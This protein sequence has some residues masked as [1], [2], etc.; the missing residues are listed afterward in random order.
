MNRSYI[1]A[2]AIFVAVVLLF[3]VGTLLNGG[4]ASPDAEQAETSHRF[5]VVVR[6]VEARM[7]PASLSLRGHTEAFREVVARAETGGR[8]AEAQRLEGTRVAAGDVLCRL[9]VDSRSA[10]VQQAEADLRA[11]QL[12]YDA[13]AELSERGHR[14]ANQVAA[15]EAA[16]DAA[17]ARL[18]AAREELAN[19]NIAAPFDGIFDG[20]AAEVGDF[21][22]A[23]DACGTVVQ[24]DPILVVAEV[25]ERHV[26]ELE[27][28]M[29]GSARLVTGQTVDGTIRFVERRADPATRTF[30]VELEAPNPDHAIRA[31]IT[32]E[33]RLDLPEEPAHR[34][35][36]S[37]LALN[38]EGVLGVRI[39]EEG[40]RVRFVPVE[41]LS[42]DG[43]Q[44]WVA[45]LP[46]RAEVIV[47]GQD[48]VADGVE[49][50]VSREGAAR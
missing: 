31:G 12:E 10:A 43:E 20:R 24:L 29:A 23:G 49:V 18:S 40:N 15:A 37:I 41:L 2:L 26:A 35:P 30:R 48:F 16:R 34:V 14:S 44:V 42:D 13:A 38:A 47:L 7:R 45:G 36:A 28:G 50:D 1:A 17:R 6:T 4:A 25:G 27:P 33:I 3:T 8:V 21:L 22:R 19:V 5:E 9:D 46:R 32:A 39:V 11:R